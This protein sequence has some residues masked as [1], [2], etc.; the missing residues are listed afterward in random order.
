MQIKT[1]K[2]ISLS[3]SL[4]FTLLLI[5]LHFLD[6]SVGFKTDF[7][8]NFALGSFGLVFFISLVCLSTAKYFLYLIVRAVDKETT[9]S[10]WLQFFILFSAVTNFLIGVFPTQNGPS[11]TISGYLHLVFAYLSFIGTGIFFVLFTFFNNQGAK[12][13]K[14]FLKSLCCILYLICLVSFP[15]LQPSLAPLMERVL[16]VLLVSTICV[17]TVLI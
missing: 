3:L 16:I 10:K 13:R 6:R 14:I 4:A 9:L 15:F 7:V 2:T 12:K 8:S 1:L 5:L 17:N 11:I